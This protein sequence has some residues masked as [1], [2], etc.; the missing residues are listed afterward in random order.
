MEKGRRWRAEE[1]ASKVHPIQQQ[2]PVPPG[3][4]EQGEPPE[5][6]SGVPFAK[7]TPN[8]EHVSS[9][10]DNYRHAKATWLHQIVPTMKLE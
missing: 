2:L 4:Y 10:A 5:G 3:M 8:W 9:A 1:T 7:K 6:V